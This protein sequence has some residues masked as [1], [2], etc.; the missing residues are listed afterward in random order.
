MKTFRCI[1]SLGLRLRRVYLSSRKVKSLFEQQLAAIF[2]DQIVKN[3]FLS[4]STI[5]M[6]IQL[7]LEVLIFFYNLWELLDFSLFLLEVVGEL[8]VAAV[9]LL[10]AEIHRLAPLVACF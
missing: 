10:G 7:S 4:I 6:S 8:K 9:H 5:K 1:C 2:V 3:D